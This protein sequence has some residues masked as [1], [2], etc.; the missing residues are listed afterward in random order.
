MRTK[1][2]VLFSAVFF[3]ITLG[4]G[5][6]VVIEERAVCNS[7]LD[8]IGDAFCDFDNL[9]SNFC[10]FDSDCI[11]GQICDNMLGECYTPVYGCSYDSDCYPGD[12]CG[13][14][15]ACY[16]YSSWIDLCDIDDDCPGEGVCTIDGV[17][18][19][20]YACTT[21]F[22]CPDDGSICNVYGWCDR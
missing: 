15:G 10:T 17:C 1:L 4:S 8:C 20:P 5:C 9:C 2:A 3:L 14:D 13:M 18:S 11:A 16:P 21:D 7:D 19:V 12:Y 22:D 6:V